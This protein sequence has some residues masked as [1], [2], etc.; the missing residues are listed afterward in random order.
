[1]EKS[2][3]FKFSNNEL[4][5]LFI[6]ELEE[7]LDVD[8][9][10]ISVKGNTVKITIVSRDRNKVFHAMEVIKETYGKVRGIFSRDREGLYSYPLE[11]LFRNFLNH[12]FPIDILIEILKKRGYIAYLDQGHLRTN[13]NFYEIN[14]LLLRIFKINQSLIEKNIDPSTREKLILQAFLEESEK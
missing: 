6:E 8:T 11:I 5:T 7:N 1:M 10:S 13:I 12:P 2:L 3:I 9:F 4:T 14:E